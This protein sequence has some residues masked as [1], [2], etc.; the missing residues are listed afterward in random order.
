MLKVATLRVTNAWCMLAHAA[1]ALKK[2]QGGEGRGEGNTQ[3]EE[4]GGGGG[5]W[6]ACTDRGLACA[7]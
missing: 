1:G 4:G 6:S 2:S 5:G 7:A 3:G